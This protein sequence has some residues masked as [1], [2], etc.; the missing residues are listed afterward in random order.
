M[1]LQKTKKLLETLQTSRVAKVEE[2]KPYNI[3][4]GAFQDQHLIL[5]VDEAIVK[6]QNE[7]EFKLF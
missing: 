6:G 1:N 7:H 2:K 5:I 4:L 3:S